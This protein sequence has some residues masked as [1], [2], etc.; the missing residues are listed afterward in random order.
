MNHERLLA[1][2]QVMEDVARELDIGFA[3]VLVSS[4]SW[5][6]D[7]KTDY[8]MNGVHL[9]EQGYARF[10]SDLFSAVFDREPPN[11]SEKLRKQLLRKAGNTSDVIAL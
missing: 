1:Y 9:T 7:T 11:V 6:S 5:L 8:T 3:N 4:R 10:A 2:T